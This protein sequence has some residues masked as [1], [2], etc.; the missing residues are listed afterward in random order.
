MPDFS[1][2]N[3]S[4]SADT[5]VGKLLL[6]GKTIR[7][8]L[9]GKW[10]VDGFSS[11]FNHVYQWWNRPKKPCKLTDHYLCFDRIDNKTSMQWE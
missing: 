6:G 8:V 3:A 11:M 9:F 1:T 5:T 7:K 10:L 4:T 2:P